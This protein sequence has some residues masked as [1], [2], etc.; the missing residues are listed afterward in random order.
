MA[1]IWPIKVVRSVLLNVEHVLL[2]FLYLEAMFSFLFDTSLCNMA[3][4]YEACGHYNKRHKKD[5]L[6]TFRRQLASKLTTKA[7]A[8]TY[9]LSPGIRPGCRTVLSNVIAKA[10]QLQVEGSEAVL[11][12]MGNWLK[13]TCKACQDM[14][15]RARQTSST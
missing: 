4:L 15:Q 2:T 1:F 7:A 14:P 6:N 9:A 8:R 10:S 13:G 12:T 5:L 3:K 11:N